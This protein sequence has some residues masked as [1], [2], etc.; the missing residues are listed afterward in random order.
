MSTAAQKLT[1][2]VPALLGKVKAMFVSEVPALLQIRYTDHLQGPNSPRPKVTKSGRRYYP[3]ANTTNELRTLYG[4]IERAV[5]PRGKGSIFDVKVGKDGLILESG[6]DTN[7]KVDAGGRSVSLIY[8]A[9]N[10]VK[11]PFLG[12]G[13]KEYVEQDYPDA[14]EQILS[15]LEDEFGS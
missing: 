1:Q 14:I 10:D 4:N 3:D 7:E 5:S 15:E 9:I 11:R 2:L 6:I 12:L 8:A 13:F